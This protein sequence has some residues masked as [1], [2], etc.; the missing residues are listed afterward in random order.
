VLRRNPMLA[1]RDGRL[2]LAAQALDSLAIGV[3][4]VALPWLVLQGG[5]SQAEAGLVYSVTVVPYLLLGL[6]AG[7]VGDRFSRRRVMLV[8]HAAQALSSAVIPLWTLGGSP[9][10]G[11]VLAAAFA[12]GAGRVFADAAAFGAVASI[13]GPERFVDGQGAVSAAWS[14]GL[15]AGPALGGALVGA[16]GAGRSLAAEAGALALASLLVAAVRTA[17]GH[18]S[19]SEVTGSIR[20]G[21]RFMVDDRGIRA[22]TLVIVAS[23]LVGAGAFALEVPLMRDAIGL[24]S[25]SVGAVLAV[26]SVATF[27]GSVLAAWLSRR[28]GGAAV[29][30]ACLLGTGLAIATL[31][32]ARGFAVALLGVMGYLLVEGVISVVAIGERQ[33]RAPPWLQGRVG[34][35]GRMVALGAMAAGSAAASALTG[36]VAISHL[37]LLMAAGTFAC[38]LLSV[39]L[40]RSIRS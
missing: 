25:G 2:F 7:S 26:G 31:G 22:Y 24:S 38:G 21:V 3:S 1:V 17:F 16:I 5:G 37:Y 33:R 8:S 36:S 39:P 35:A 34:I 18:G 15:F 30:S 29:F 6:V 28:F 11:V 40:L 19:E 20:E 12:V 10:V 23:N 13:V 32:L 4:L 27:A 9:P 14:V